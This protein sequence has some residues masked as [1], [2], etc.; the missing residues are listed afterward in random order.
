MNYNPRSK[1]KSICF[2]AGLP[3]EY[4]FPKWGVEA[5]AEILIPTEKNSKS[6]HLHLIVKMKKEL[7]VDE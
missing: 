7:E 2:S 5:K 4:L 1:I 6:I 3:R